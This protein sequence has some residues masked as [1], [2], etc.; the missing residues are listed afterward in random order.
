MRYKIILIMVILGI[1]IFSGC[2]EDKTV[3]FSEKA[4][5]T[6]TLYGDNTV[7]VK[8]GSDDSGLSGTYRID[9][10]RVILSL[11]PFGTVI[12]LKRENN[13]LIF[14]KKD[15]NYTYVRQ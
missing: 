5:E 7:Y 1:A 14:E 6:I 2:V 9:G 3:Y 10:N 8:D 13:K 11:A 4:N 15:K 12:E